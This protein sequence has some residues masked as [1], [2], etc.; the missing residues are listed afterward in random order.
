M[1]SLNPRHTIGRI[2]TEP[3][4]LHGLAQDHAA[5]LALVQGVLGFSI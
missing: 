1:S 5:A 4:L 3:V 2:L